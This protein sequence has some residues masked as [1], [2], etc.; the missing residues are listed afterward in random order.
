MNTETVDETKKRK[1]ALGIIH[2]IA[3]KVEKQKKSEGEVQDVVLQAAFEELS[4]LGPIAFE[5]L[6]FTFK[7]QT[8]KDILVVAGERALPYLESAIFS[9]MPQH[10]RAFQ[11]R[12][13]AEQAIRVLGSIQ[14]IA[15]PLLIRTYREHQD[16]HIQIAAAYELSQ[17]HQGLAAVKEGLSNKNDSLRYAAVYGLAWVVSNSYYG[18][19]GEERLSER[20]EEFIKLLLPFL[21]DPNPKIRE[22]V[23]R[24]LVEIKRATLDIIDRALEDKDISIRS[25]A[26]NGLFHYKI[27]RSNAATL[28][29][30]FEDRSSEIS[31]SAIDKMFTQRYTDQA[32]DAPEA[33]ADAIIDLLIV[34]STGRPS[35]YFNP[36]VVARALGKVFEN[37]PRLYDQTL[38]QLRELAY[39]HN[40]DIRRRCV[41]VAKRINEGDFTALVNERAKDNPE[42]ANAIYQSLGV[43]SDMAS[44]AD[45]ISEADPG[46]IQKIAGAQI[47]LL[48]SYYQ[49]ALNEAKTSFSWA[50]RSTIL[51]FLVLIGLLI[52]LLITRSQDTV[53]VLAAISSMFAQFLSGAQFYMYRQSQKKLAYFH[54][55]L[56][57][58]QRLLLANSVCESLE[59]DRKQ[60]SRMELVKMI[61]T[62]DFPHESIPR[63]E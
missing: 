47:K 29:K 48:G 36:A 62:L 9:T 34:R 23:L 32:E 27:D 61:A 53:S 4:A 7:N 43:A 18:F 56:D 46:D 37:N 26:L 30:I 19:R 24:L 10:M 58:T 55:S 40:G 5:A 21:E 6:P 13:Y 33:V 63:N 59:G 17:T 20:D 22:R 49:D 39:E 52:Y 31:N 57:Q 54:K 41:F 35:E 38:Q 11:D 42:K 14:S 2:E 15:M 28:V 25:E 60:Q 45:Q 51:S 1:E 50:I 12:Q 8:I 16:S 44:I 3:N